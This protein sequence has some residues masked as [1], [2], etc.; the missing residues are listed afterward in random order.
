MLSADTLR[1]VPRGGPSLPLF[2]GRPQRAAGAG[3]GAGA[4]VYVVLDGTDETGKPLPPEEK[5]GAPRAMAKLGPDNP[6]Q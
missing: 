4:A 3:A 1:A 6:L 2:P 5:V